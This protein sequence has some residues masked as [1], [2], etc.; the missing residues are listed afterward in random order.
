MN[1]CLKKTASSSVR[2]FCAGKWRGLS[3]AKEKKLEKAC[4]NYQQLF[5]FAEAIMGNEILHDQ[6]VGES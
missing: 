1:G 5:F 6:E 4:S 2:Y 3:P